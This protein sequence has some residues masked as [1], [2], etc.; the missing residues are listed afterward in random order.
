MTKKFK[1]KKLKNT[2]LLYELLIRQM[3][4]DVLQGK[5]PVSFNIIKKYFKQSSPLTEELKLYNTLINSKEKDSTFALSIVDSVIKTKDK[6]NTQELKKQKYNLIKE[7]L[8]NFDKE[9][10]L[11]TQ[12]D[13]YKLYASI[14]NILEYRDSENPNLFQRNKLYIANH[15]KSD[16]VEAQQEKSELME[17]IDP[18][19]KSLTFKLLTEKFNNKFS[20]L[21]QN[22]KKILRHF[23]FN[24]VDSQDTKKFIQEQIEFLDKKLAASIKTTKNEVL[25]IK[26]K[27]VKNLLPQIKNSSFITES[28]YLSLIRYN[29]LIK[30]LNEK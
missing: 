23:I 6:L 28:H 3:T 2:G 9:S 21:S 20:S 24:S 27:E 17:G 8:D 19:L 12:I 18:E 22:Q 10:F 4:S 5:K 13:N 30:E 7:I 16:R 29:E 1:H 11:K 26:L 15:I 14:F 25:K